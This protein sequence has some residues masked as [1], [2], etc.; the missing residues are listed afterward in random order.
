MTD[1]FRAGFQ[2]TKVKGMMVFALICAIAALYWGWSLFNTVGLSPGDGYGGVLAPV[3]VRLAWGLTVAV[4]G[5]LF[6]AGMWVFGRLYATRIRYDSAADA[7]HIGTLELLATRT[8][9]V[10]P[11]DVLGSRYHHGRMEGEGVDAPWFTV[12]L[13]GWRGPLIVDAQGVFPDRELA[14]RLLKMK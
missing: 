13:K 8:T 12:R 6:L 4:L 10:S 9:I 1:I 3:G 14:A 2:L 7:L 11:S 5:L